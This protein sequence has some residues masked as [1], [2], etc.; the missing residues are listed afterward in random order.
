MYAIDIFSSSHTYNSA[1]ILSV[2]TLPL[3]LFHLSALDAREATASVF[4]RPIKIHELQDVAGVGNVV[5]GMCLLHATV[6]PVSVVA[7]PASPCHSLWVPALCG[8]LAALAAFI[9]VMGNRKGLHD[10]DLLLEQVCFVKD[11][12][13]RACF[14][15]QWP[16][17]IPPLS[18]A[19][20]SR[21]HEATPR[22]H[23][24]LS[25]KV[26]Q[27]LFVGIDGLQRTE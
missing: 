12:A 23:L 5:D 26:L 20:G 10:A 19:S 16:G 18:E 7:A 22:W 4:Y 25:V 2:S 24:V 27:G 1:K 9:G 13:N 21:V 17:E 6:V 11:V 15:P 3:P 8:T 14:P